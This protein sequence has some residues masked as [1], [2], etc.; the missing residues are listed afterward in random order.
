MFIVSEIITFR[1]SLTNLT[2]V[3]SEIGMM[4]TH[5][6][7]MVKFGILIYKRDEIEQVKNKLRDVQF[8]YV[9]IGKKGKFTLVGR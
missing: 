2:A 4:F 8:E 9:G 3:L 1:K 5:L 6:V 7:G